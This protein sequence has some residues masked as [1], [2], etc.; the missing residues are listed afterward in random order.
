MLKEFKEFAMKGNI[1][2]LAIGVVIGGAFQKIVNSLVQ[3]LIMPMISILIGKVD[4]SN[5]VLTVGETKI[6]YGN[7]ITAVIDFLIIA[8]SIF[9]V[10][11]YLNKLNRL[12]ELGDIAASKIDKKGKFKR[13]NKKEA[14]EEVK[15]EVKPE[16]K[17]CP[18][19]YTEIKYEATRCPN[20]TSVLEEEKKEEDKQMEEIDKQAQV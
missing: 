15:E 4:F 5:L 20:C 1:M 18:Y 10:V 19:C 16:T 8:F 9:L 17:L 3:D 12:K 2:D 6:T 7:F 14:S 11:R 13:K